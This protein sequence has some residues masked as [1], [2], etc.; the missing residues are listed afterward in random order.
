VAL[1]VDLELLFKLLSAHTSIDAL[2]AEEVEFVVFP[3][4]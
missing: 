4:N 3:A 1:A 2:R